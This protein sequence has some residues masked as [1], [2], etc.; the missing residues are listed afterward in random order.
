MRRMRGL[1]VLTL[2][3]LGCGN[4]DDEPG[5][6]ASVPESQ[7]WKTSLLAVPRT[8][9]AELKVDVRVTLGNPIVQQ[10]YFRGERELFG[11]APRFTPNVVTFD[12]QNRPYIRVGI[13]RGKDV[14]HNTD[15][16]KDGVV[17]TLND[18][19]EWLRL[20][21]RDD[22]LAAYPDWNGVY[23][24]GT[25]HEE[26]IVFDEGGDAYMLA[27]HARF[28]NIDRQL[29]LY[30]RDRAR[31]WQVYALPR[32]AVRAFLE[33]P[34]SQSRMIGPPTILMADYHGDNLTM[35]KPTKTADG[36]LSLAP[37]N[38]I[39]TDPQ[40]QMGGTQAGSNAT[41]TVGNRTHLVYLS[42]NPVPGRPGTPQYIVTYDHDTG[43]TTPPVLLGV[44]GHYGDPDVH[45]RPAIV[46]DSKG[47]LH[48][49][50]GGHADPFLYTRSLVPNSSTDGWTA[51]VAIGPPYDPVS[52]D[53]AYT[54]ISM[55][56]DP[57]DTIHV[58]ARKID[59]RYRMG[60]SYL[61][62][63]VGGPWEERGPLVVPFR[64]YYS[65]WD[66]KLTVD[67]QGR[68]FLRYSYYGDNFDYEGGPEVT[69]YRKKW[70]DELIRLDETRRLVH[71]YWSG[72]KHHDPVLLMSDDG[73][74][75]WRLATT[76]DFIRGR[77]S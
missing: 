74:N 62:K 69:A 18:K 46:V 38:L 76:Q 9:T 57:R 32:S 43:Q 5:A 63:T 33:V 51:P 7:D 49:L 30:S 58:V 61:R 21:F 54:Y 75:T 72:Q 20:S 48:V 41:A 70:P 17:Q 31:S 13:R 60:L 59:S 8:R 44:N 71:G 65:T 11:Y 3:F 27:N 52:N 40:A 47:Y 64:S 2:A 15:D 36:R 14:V 53:G 45:N 50:L 1:S 19:G 68:L 37:A 66:A 34:D 42:M 28:S 29:L 6:P 12:L 25:Q 4:A 10:P 56:I 22:I 39:L 67:R 73:G 24:T 35:L 26:R 77:R 55:V 16:C 23:T